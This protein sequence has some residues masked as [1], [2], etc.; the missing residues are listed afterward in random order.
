MLPAGRRRYEKCADEGAEQVA[1]VDI[2]AEVAAFDGA[3]DE[4]VDGGVDEAAGTFVEPGGAADN[5]VEGGSD[6]LL[7]GEVVDEEE[8]PGAEGVEGRKSGGEFA[9]GGGEFFD[10]GTID[11]FDEGVAGGKVTVESAG[12]DLGLAGDVVEAGIGTVAGECFFSD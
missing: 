4:G 11:G 3:F 1:G 7:G 2:F 10:L 12:S 8:H 6:D 9:F 5:A